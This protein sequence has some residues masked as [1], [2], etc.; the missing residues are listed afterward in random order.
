LALTLLPPG[1]APGRHLEGVLDAAARA[2]ALTQQLLAFSRK[3]VLQPREIDLN[4]VVR[5]MDRLLRRILGEDVGIETRLAPD[6]WAVRADTGQL[7]QVL[8]NLAVN[9]RDAMPGGGAL[10][11]ETANVELDE[12]YCRDHQAAVPGPHVML[13]VSDTGTGL[14]REAREHLFEPFFTTKETGKG[15]GLGLSTVYGIVHQS[16]GSIWAYSEPGHGT[17]FKIYL[18]RAAEAPPA[19]AAA[20]LET[21][22]GTET[23]LLAEDNAA[24][25]EVVTATL[26]VLGY[27]VLPAAGPAAAL[28]LARAHTEPL[29]LLVSD[30]VM[31][32]MS[33][34]EL[35]RRVRELRP[36]CRVLFVSG[37]T[38][39][40]I[41]HHG[42]IDEG[43]SFL[44]KP[45]GAGV[46]AR[47][48]RQ[49]LDAP[50]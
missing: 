37:Y 14:T 7:E 44:Q 36:G 39:N 15:T 45:F 16:G 10:V 2:A 43:V 47:T 22:G 24:V 33:G 40:A 9:S 18:P 6:L 21:R 3:Q 49:V 11:L 5:G 26:E 1:S 32:G 31:P 25:R 30:V 35:A 42:V 20:E 17:T 8:L 29:H 34:P 4:A 28:E 38:E 27:R 23:I 13:A 48:V 19:A 41:V 12:A 50:D 46:L